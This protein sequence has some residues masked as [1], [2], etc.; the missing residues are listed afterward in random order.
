MDLSCFNIAL[1]ILTSGQ[2]LFLITYDL[3]D[4]HNKLQFSALLC[5]DVGQAGYNANKFVPSFIGVFSV[6]NK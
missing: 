3:G 1:K 5:A 4:Q 2:N 6:L